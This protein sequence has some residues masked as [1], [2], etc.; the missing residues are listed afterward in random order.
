MR[1]SHP[2]LQTILD[3]TP[4]SAASR[5]KESAVITGKR[6]Q[7]IIHIFKN[8][9]IGV[10]GDFFLDAYFDCDP[11]LDEKSI[12]TGKTCYQV[13]R[14]R[15]YAG[16]AG[17]VAANLKA[18]GVD[19]VDIVGFCGDDGE[20]YELRR[21]MVNLNLILEGFFPCP[22]RFTPTYGKPC[23]VDSGA[24]NPNAISELERLD[25]KNRRSTPIA[26]QNKMMA[27]I[28]NHLDIWDGLVIVD[29]VSTP[30]CGVLTSRM[31]R[32]LIGESRC[33]PDLPFLVDSREHIHLFEHMI[34]KPNQFE[35]ARAV[36]R[37]R[38]KPT[39]KDSTEHAHALS[40][41]AC[42]PVFLTL[43]EK[44]MLVANGPRVDHAPSFSVDGPTDP[45][46]AGD[47]ASAA[48]VAS[49]SAGTTLLEAADI[50][51]IVASITVQQIGATGTAPPAQIK[52]RHR[53]IA[54][55]G[56]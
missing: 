20:G 47:S 41:K 22:D 24:R 36:G 34:L 21:A 27:Y 55:H 32:F 7:D 53:E 14:T 8:L 16:A 5:S 44:G 56:L 12:E 6:L 25:I 40:T 35:A 42:C 52:R 49:L 45:V 23:Y 54:R 31:R 37:G 17:T 2:Q 48:L 4:K 39:F 30:N 33:R 28:R 46:G 50:G 3:K 38:R 18:L 13:V 10:V 43:A 26:I 29:Q 15:R 11:I 19:K 51:N 9:H 1:S